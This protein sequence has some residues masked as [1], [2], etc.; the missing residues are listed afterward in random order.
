MS[1]AFVIEIGLHDIH[2]VSHLCEN[3]DSVVESFEF[4][5]NAINKLKFS[6]RTD[7]PLMITNVIVV[8]EEE[9]RVVTAL[10]ELHHQICESSF[11]YFTSV[12]GKL[13]S[14]LA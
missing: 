2:E 11:T 4:R 10:S 8:F 7:D 9:I 6:R 14:G 3:E 5:Q 1:N 13:H 12:V